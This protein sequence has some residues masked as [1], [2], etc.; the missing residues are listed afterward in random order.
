MRSTHIQ[1]LLKFPLVANKSTLGWPNTLQMALNTQ[2]KGD[3]FVV[4]T[5]SGQF[6]WSA[7]MMSFPGMYLVD[8]VTECSSDQVIISFAGLYTIL[9]TEPPISDMPSLWLCCSREQS[10]LLGPWESSVQGA[11]NHLHI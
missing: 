9:E 7:K 5:R 8:S 6:N 1:R 2:G 10:I 4:R 3:H 11:L